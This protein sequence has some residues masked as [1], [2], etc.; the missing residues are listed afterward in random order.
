MNHDIQVYTSQDIRYTTSKTGSILYATALGWPTDATLT[1]HTLY[2]GNPYL[3]SPVCNVKLVGTD[4]GIPFRQRPDGLHLTLPITPPKSLPTD[5]A[6]VF[7]V[8][9][10][11]PAAVHS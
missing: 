10:H 6:Y 2:A 5:I 11:C 1:L 4:Q 3:P 7:T 8:A 9:T